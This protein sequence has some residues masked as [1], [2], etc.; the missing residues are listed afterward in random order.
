MGA[1]YILSSALI[2]STAPLLVHLMAQGVN[3]FAFNTLYQL[4]NIILSVTFLVA[5]KHHVFKSSAHPR[6]GYNVVLREAFASPARSLLVWIIVGSFNYALFIWSTAFLETAVSAIIFELW[7]IVLVWRMTTTTLVK[8]RQLQGWRTHVTKKHWYLSLLA[9]VGLIVVLSSQQWDSLAGLAFS[10]DTLLGA[11]LACLAAIGTALYIDASLQYGKV[12]YHTLR[13]KSR[14]HRT[15]SAIKTQLWLVLLGFTLARVIV[16]ICSFAIV[17][18]NPGLEV[19]FQLSQTAIMGA[20]CLGVCN[21]L[22][23][24]LLRLGNINAARPEHNILNLLSP[25]LAI[26]WLMGIGIDVHRFDLFVVGSSLVLTMN[27]LILREPDAAGVA[28]RP[29]G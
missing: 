4:I 15:S 11:S 5:T 13:E 14:I 10:R 29:A 24:V 1:L 6:L 8:G 7:P 22:S 12:L 27:M 20:I 16:C 21:T 9:G 18:A 3:P 28:R 26:I 23:V 19:G 25:V 17:S 2:W